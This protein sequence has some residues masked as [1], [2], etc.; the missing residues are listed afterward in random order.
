MENEL[1]WNNLKKWL[2]FY[3]FCKTFQILLSVWWLFYF[4]SNFIYIYSKGSSLQCTYITCDSGFV[5]T[6]SEP[7]SEP[8]MATFTDTNT[9]HFQITFS[10]RHHK[11]LIHQETLLGIYAS[12]QT[13]DCQN[14]YVPSKDFDVSLFAFGLPPF[15][16]MAYDMHVSND[17]I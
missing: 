9:R 12:S 7:L 16:A 1:W 8:M 4:T 15:G 11:S 14:A 6:G 3:L 13:V 5:C 2:L 10:L 17:R